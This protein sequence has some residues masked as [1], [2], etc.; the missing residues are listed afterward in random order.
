MT[1]LGRNTFRHQQGSDVSLSKT[2]WQEALAA[3]E[4]EFAALPKK[5][6][7]QDIRVG[8][9]SGRAVREN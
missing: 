2:A 6:T 3:L 1:D 4:A 7:A 5:G 8:G 9:Q